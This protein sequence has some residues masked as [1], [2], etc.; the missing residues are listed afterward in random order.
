MF[1]KQTANTDVIIPATNHTLA[2]FKYPD[3]RPKIQSVI[4]G[5][6]YR[7]IIA[8]R[9]RSNG[10]VEPITVELELLGGRTSVVVGANG[11]NKGQG[12]GWNKIEPS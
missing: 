9:V 5:V 1:D 7:P 12:G 8:W 3:G 6:E 2:R 11:I 10:R 4:S